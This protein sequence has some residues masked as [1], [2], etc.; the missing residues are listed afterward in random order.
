MDSSKVL[1]YDYKRRFGVEIETNSLSGRDFIGF[2][3]EKNELPDGINYIGEKIAKNLK[4]PVT[5]H[6][7]HPTHNNNSWVLK[8]DRSCGIEI[9]SP[10][11]KGRF[12]LEQICEVVDIISKDSKII[13]D[14]RCSFH[15][16]V[17]L[18]DC[19]E[20]SVA[21]I[22][23]W[24]VKCEAVFIDSLPVA[25]K[26]SRYCQCIGASDIFYHDFKDYIEINGEL[27][28]Q[29]Y[30]TINSFHMNRKK[31]NS[32]EFRP[33]GNE[34][35]KNSEIT[36]NW[37]RLLVHFVEMAK[38]QSI[39]RAWLNVN[40]PW[41]GLLWLDPKDVFKFLGF[42]DCELDENLTE[43]RNW[44]LKRL[45]TNIKTD[46]LG[47]WSPEARFKAIE[48]VEELISHFRLDI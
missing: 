39:P 41:R 18:D 43:V 16:H 6:P 45:K 48:E 1:K 14:D 46:L 28:E 12:G 42:L 37:I 36:K 33:L 30:F 7:W 40:D 17:N 31:R 5:I 27:G 34:G 2:P 21:A 44:F 24:W 29:K 22:L 3:L 4:I 15:V 9:C 26:K 19:N 23:A 32:I 35:C 13:V 25:R 8:P 47:F 20:V 10:V 11:S 38:K